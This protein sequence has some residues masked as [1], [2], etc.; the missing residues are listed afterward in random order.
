[1]RYKVGYYK[2]SQCICYQLNKVVLSSI[3]ITATD[4]HKIV[5]NS[6]MYRVEIEKWVLGVMSAHT[7]SYDNL[8]SFRENKLLDYISNQT[9][10]NYLNPAN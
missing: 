9:M 7:G 5:T 2:L 4:E 6:N 1:M 8:T 3:F 10:K